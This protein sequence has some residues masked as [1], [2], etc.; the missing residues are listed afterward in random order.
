MVAREGAE[1]CPRP[2]IIRDVELIRCDEFSRMSTTVSG[3]MCDGG[4]DAKVNVEPICTFR[5]YTR[6]D[7]S[8]IID[9]GACILIAPFHK[10]AAGARY[11]CA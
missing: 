10:I 11:M 1:A 9:K 6:P 3:D 2:R 4:W 8:R 7:F 5:S